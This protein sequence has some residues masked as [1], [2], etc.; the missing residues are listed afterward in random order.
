MAN[1]GLRIMP[2]LLVDAV[3]VTLAAPHCLFLRMHHMLLA[4]RLCILLL[5]LCGVDC[6][7]VVVSDRLFS[8][9]SLCMDSCAAR[10]EIPLSKK[11]AAVRVLRDLLCMLFCGSVQLF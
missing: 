11:A 6:R 7:G 9:A 5:A 3:L 8:A 1:E 10:C 4:Q 2:K